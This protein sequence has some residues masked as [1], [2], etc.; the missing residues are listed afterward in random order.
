MKRIDY[1]V[2]KV[3]KALH[4]VVVE[5]KITDEELMGAIEFLTEIGKKKEFHLL[6]DVLGISVLVNEMTNPNE[7]HSTPSNVE[8][9]LY[10]NGSPLLTEPIKLSRNGNSGDTLFVFGSVVDSITGKEL[11]GVEFDVWQTNHLGLYENEDPEQEDFNLRG[12]F[13]TGLEGKYEF[14]TVVPVPYEISK[15]GPVGRLL[16]Q[17][18][19]HAFR[20]AHIHFK[21]THKGY[22]PLTTQ[23]FFHGDQY[24]DND[25]ISGVKKELI[26]ELQKHSS[27]QELNNRC[28][29]H[30][31]FTCQFNVALKPING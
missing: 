20:P 9:P 4:E 11:P 19:R 30:P 12:R 8:G 28:L 21:V 26:Y 13:R 16:A 1:V 25:V 27:K 23:I 14:E 3:V 22:V 18:D 2:S 31:F 29:Q 5:T 10:R 17:L 6:S 24:L 15:Y 7:D